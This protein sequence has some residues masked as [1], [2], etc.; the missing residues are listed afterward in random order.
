MSI[1]PRAVEE[2]SLN[3]FEI[4]RSCNINGFSVHI[5]SISSFG[6]TFQINVTGNFLN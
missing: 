3:V 6:K 2:S 4:S 5:C 1:V